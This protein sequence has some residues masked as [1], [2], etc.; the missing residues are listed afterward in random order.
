MEDSEKQEKKH[1]KTSVWIEFVKEW[2]MKHK[3]HYGTAMSSEK[4]KLAYR[5]KY[6]KR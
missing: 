6:H 5:K 3:V 1:K 4:C 2:A